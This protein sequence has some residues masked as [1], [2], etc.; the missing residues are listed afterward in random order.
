[1]G[2]ST[3]STREPRVHIRLE[4]GS[5]CDAEDARGG[6]HRAL[7]SV[8]VADAATR[9]RVDVLWPSLGLDGATGYAAARARHTMTREGQTFA[10]ESRWVTYVNFVSCRILSFCCI[11]ARGSDAW[12]LCGAGDNDAVLWIIVAFTSARFAAMAST[13]SSIVSLTPGILARPGAS[14]RRGRWIFGPRRSRSRGRDRLRAG[15]VAT[16]P[17]VPGAL[18][19][20]ADVDPVL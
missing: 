15:G 14:C 11:R 20:R 12:Q 4:T 2:R 6:V 16:Q 10:G 9:A 5:R 8:I 19:V 17:A 1:M 7:A 3:S 13:G 18:A